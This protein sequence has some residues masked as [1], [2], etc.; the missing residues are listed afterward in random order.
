MK[1]ILP[2]IPEKNLTIG[3]PRCE[4][5]LV[6]RMPCHRAR[7]LLVSSERLQIFFKITQVEQLQQM[8]ARCSY[9]PVAVVVP[10]QIHD[11]WLVSVKCCE[12]L[13]ALRIPQL[14]RLLIV[15]AAR[16]HQ[17]LL[18]MP[19]D[20]LNIGAMS[21]HHALFLTPQ[22]IENPQSSVVAARCKLRI[23]WTKAV[24][25]CIRK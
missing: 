25:S 21:S 3:T 13:T 12:R 18:G 19:V 15:L 1:N 20:A 16:H 11:C 22:K 4:K 5:S 10:L 8:I 24:K 23:R 17:R 9:Q 2:N 7:L 6:N 14:N